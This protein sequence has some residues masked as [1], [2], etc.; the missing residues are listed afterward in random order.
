MHFILRWGREFIFSLFTYIGNDFHFI[1]DFI[2]KLIL[3]AILL[4][5]E[6]L[7]LSL[8]SLRSAPRSLRLISCRHQTGN[9]ARQLSELGLRAGHAAPGRQH[10]R[11]IVVDIS[12]SLHTVPCKILCFGGIESLTISSLYFEGFLYA[13]PG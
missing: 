13:Q 4:A 12:H 10:S 9:F 2:R 6:L 8:V 3:S 5:R 1:G 11:D 7:A